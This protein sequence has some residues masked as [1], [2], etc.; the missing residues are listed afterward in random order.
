M[1]AIWVDTDFGFDDLWAL[2][3][4]RHFGRNVAGV[5]LVAG[6]AP[7]AQV[8]VNAMGAKTAYGFDWPVWQ[9]ATKPL[10]RPLETAERILGPTGMRTRGMVLPKPD[11]N[12]P[13]EGA[14][15]ALG[16]WLSDGAGAEREVLALGPLT[17]IALLLQQSPELADRTTRLIWMGGS[18]GRGNHTPLAEYNAFADADALAYVLSTGIRIDIVDLSFCRKVTFGAKD[19]PLTDQLTGDLLGGYL[20]IAL[21]RGRSAMAIY[22]PLAAL[23]A[24]QPDC[25]GFSPCAVEVSTKSD[26]SYGA[27]NVSH[28]A[29]SKV[30]LATTAGTDLARLCLSALKREAMD[31]PR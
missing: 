31:G 16:N 13:S 19:M 5:S 3:V 30:R 11:T 10:K 23:A 14:V 26:E 24:A 17:N 29:A 18:A 22:D 12:A 9:G 25:I 20:D 6:N 28:V 2:L 1:T 7:L 21:E 27:T 8:T 15:Q 4:L